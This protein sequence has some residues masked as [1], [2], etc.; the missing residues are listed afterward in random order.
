MQTTVVNAKIK[1][2]RGETAA[3]R[4]A[5]EISD[6]RRNRNKAGTR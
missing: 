5:K 4:T 1:I 2:I 3:G 6:S